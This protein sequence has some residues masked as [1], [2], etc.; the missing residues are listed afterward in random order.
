MPGTRTHQRTKKADRM[1][2]HITAEA[3]E[4]G[5][6]KGQEERVAW[7]TVHKTMSKREAHKKDSGARSRMKAAS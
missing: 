3:K 4:E 1:A 2:K 7:A 6:Y 5:R